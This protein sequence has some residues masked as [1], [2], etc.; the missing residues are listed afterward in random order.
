MERCVSTQVYH[1]VIFIKKGNAFDLMSLNYKTGIKS[2]ILITIFDYQHRD[3]GATLKVA[4]AGG[5]GLISDSKWGKG[6]EITFSQ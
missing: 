1:G 5:G 3:R 2:V 6:V 4:W